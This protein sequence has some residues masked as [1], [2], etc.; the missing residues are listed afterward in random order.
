MKTV[1]S[2]K[3]KNKNT[4][5]AISFD[6]VEVS[7]VKTS[8]ASSKV[9]KR[10]V[11]DKSTKKVNTSNDKS[12]IKSFHKFRKRKLKKYNSLT[13]DF[14]DKKK[15]IFKS[16]EDLEELQDQ[17]DKEIENEDNLSIGL[18]ILI[19]SVCLVVGFVAGY[20][21]YRLIFS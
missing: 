20:M 1:K 18:I 21:A 10:K 4:K 14:L 13:D 17:I 12:D 7:N 3:I 9:R 6:D 2:R 8:D 16:N 19:L 15:D 11:Y 5:P